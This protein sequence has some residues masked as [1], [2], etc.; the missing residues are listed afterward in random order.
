MLI[1][2][3]PVVNPGKQSLHNTRKNQEKSGTSRVNSD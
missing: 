2:C 1:E 3:K